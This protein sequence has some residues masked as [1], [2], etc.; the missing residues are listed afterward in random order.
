[1]RE[2]LKK[3][4]VGAAITALL[5]CSCEGSS[6]ENIEQRDDIII[7]LETVH[8]PLL[9]AEADVSSSLDDDPPFYSV[10]GTYA[11]RYIADFYNSERE[12]MSEVVDGSRITITF[13][14]YTFD[15]SSEIGDDEIP[16]LSNKPTDELRYE[17][18]GLNTEYWDFT[19]LA[20]VAGGGE[21]LSGIDGL[22]IGCREGDEVEIYTTFNMAYGS[23][24]F[25]TIDKE[26][27][28]RFR[29]TID[30]VE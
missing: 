28:M 23:V 15:G 13:D 2:L 19:P 27:A 26:S 9:I 5:L 17:E 21:L 30:S 10:Y 1:M 12:S 22:L 7:Y 3:I 29:C 11:Y 16:I 6:E 20:V 18:A 4:S 25:G 8:S 14:L 24:I